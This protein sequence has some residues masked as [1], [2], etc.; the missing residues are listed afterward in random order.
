MGDEKV[1]AVELTGA[2][3]EVL[4]A[5]LRQWSGPAACTEEFATAMGFRGVDGLLKDA[6]R[7]IADLEAEHPLTP[8]DWARAILATEVAFA[9]D[10]VGAGVEWGTVTGLTDEHTI[11]VL[12]ALQRKLVGVVYSQSSDPVEDVNRH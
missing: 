1:V 2:E 3:V 9:S 6:A 8:V 11:G 12:R 4:V 7:L 10:A 5:G